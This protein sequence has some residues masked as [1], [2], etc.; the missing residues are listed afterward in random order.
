MRFAEREINKWMFFAFLGIFLVL[1]F[2]AMNW[3]ENRVI[4]KIL[5]KG[6]E[7]IPD[8][9]I[10][11]L[12]GV[13]SGEKLTGINLYEVRRRVESHRFVKQAN[14]YTNLPDV[15]IIEIVERNPIAMV[16]FQDKIYYLDYEGYVIPYDEVKKVFAVP[17]LDLDYKPVDVFSDSLG[18][19]RK[20]YEFI[21]LAMKE[22]VYDLIS[23]V[24]LKNGEFV[25]LAG[26]SAVI[27]FLGNDNI[28]KRLVALRNF[29][30]Q[31]VQGKA[32]PVYVDLRYDGKIYAKFKSKN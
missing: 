22:N 8:D 28:E 30:E 7:T 27:V 26:D 11:K 24:N 31:E 9:T 14:V 6:N 32:S 17:L 16:I 1:I 29:W 19:L 12:S 10:L 20:Q 21:R 4:N 5:V 13:K 25:V 3:R 23:E 15:L 2:G 18:K